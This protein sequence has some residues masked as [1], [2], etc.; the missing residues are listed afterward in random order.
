M[1]RFLIILS[2]LIG[3]AAVFANPASAQNGADE[4]ESLMQKIR[5]DFVSNPD[6]DKELT[7]YNEQDG[8]FTDVDY[9]SIQRTNWPPLVERRAYRDDVNP[10]LT[11][12]GR[13]ARFDA[14]AAPRTLD[15]L[16]RT[17]YL[18]IAWDAPPAEIERQMREL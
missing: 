3:M 9:A 16:K 7:L 17:M 10:F 11:G 6:I 8:S 12:F 2:C 15:I 18:D 5:Q 4:F 13:D 1:K 14:D